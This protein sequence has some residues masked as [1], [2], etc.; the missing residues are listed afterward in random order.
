MGPLSKAPNLAV[1]A[2][3]LGTTVSLGFY[4][5]VAAL[6]QD[7]DHALSLAL[8]DA[9]FVGAIALGFGVQVALFV[10]LRR[11]QPHSSAKP[12]AATGGA[13]TA[14]MLACCA[15]HLIDLAPALGVAGMATLLGT[16]RVPLL[17]LAVGINAFGIVRGVRHLRQQRANHKADSTP[18][19]VVRAHEHSHCALGA[20]ESTNEGLL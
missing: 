9:P 14:S 20:R 11:L 12:L 3:A 2:G 19:P 1:I 10:H 6:A 5:L 4:L 16:Y 8:A 13:S 18:Q 15:H 7:W 17:W